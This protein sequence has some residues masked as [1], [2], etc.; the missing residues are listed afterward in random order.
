MA[1]PYFLIRHQVVDYD[2]WRQVYVGHAAERR[3]AGFREVRLF[4]NMENPNEVIILFEIDDVEK[5]KAFLESDETREKMKE[6]QVTDT[7]DVYFLS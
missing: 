5:A 7:P 1:K 2:Q 6:A 3:Q 4:R